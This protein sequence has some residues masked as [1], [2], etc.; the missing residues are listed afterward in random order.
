MVGVDDSSL[1]AQVGLPGLRVGGRLALSYIHQVNRVNS[2]N[3]SVMMS[4]S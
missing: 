2:R 4:A 3:G 1:A